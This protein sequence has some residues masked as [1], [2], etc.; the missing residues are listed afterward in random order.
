MKK[1]VKYIIIALVVLLMNNTACNDLTETV[2]SDLTE[3]GYNYSPDEIYSVIGPVYQNMREMHSHAGYSIMQESTT[4]I[5]VMPANASGWDDG[6][7]YKKMHLHTWNAEAPQIRNLWSLLY[8]GVLHSNRIIEQLEKEIVPVPSNLTK[9]SFIAEMKV[10]RAFYYWLLID[11][12]GDAPFVTTTSQELPAITTKGEIFQSIVND[13]TS[14]LAQLSSENNTLMYGRF[15]RWAAKALLANLY[16]NSIVYTGKAEWDR[17]LAECND[18]INSGLYRLEENY[19]DCFAPHNENSV[20]TI[21]AIPYDAINGGGLYL[22]YT[23]HSATRY[24]YN[25]ATT[26]WGAGSAKAISQFID[27]YDP[28]D[29]RLDDT[30]E[31]GLQYAADGVTPL[32][33]TYDRAGQQLNYSKDL[34]DGL[35]TTEDEGYRIKKY[36]PEL[37]GQYNMN[38]DVPFFRYAQVLM[39]KAECLLRKGQDTEAAT[40]VTQVRER[41]FKNTPSKATI[42]VTQLKANSKYK[43][44]YVEDYKIVE[45]GDASPIEFGGLYDELGYEFACEWI[46]RRDMIRFGTYTTKS[47]LSHKPE[48]E[49]AKVFPI[50]QVVIDANPNIEQNTDYQ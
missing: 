4:D 22:N 32:M 26:P 14:S 24:K 25:L 41:A 21:F 8:R 39:M 12:F 33:C 35:Y 3:A 6:G 30:W 40:I 50:P 9:E 1:T 42:S 36:L 31:H 23:F 7:I 18:I 19:S 49:K 5:L 2:Y 17:C 29:T 45:H 46:R 38:N 27:T 20:E 37:G 43:Y 28:D 13:V 10:A 48:G 44:G 47:W 16:L 15:N 11:N 34:P